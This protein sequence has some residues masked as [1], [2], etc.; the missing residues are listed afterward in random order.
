MNKS[1]RLAL[2]ATLAFG[3]AACGPSLAKKKD[4][5][6]IH[7][8]LGEVH[9]R[10]RN[11]ADALKELTK[12]IELNPGDANYYNALGLAYFMKGMNPEAYK[13]FDKAV[14]IDPKLSDAHL[15]KSALY[16]T[17]RKWDDAIKSAQEATRNIFYR[18]P[19]LAYNNIGWAYY[20]RGDYA[21][22]IDNYR[23]AIQANYNYA[24]AHYNMGLALE[25]SNRLKEAVESYKSAVTV[26]PA[27]LDA[28]FNL[29][30]ALAKSKDKAGAQKA[31]E[32]VVELAPES[33]K[34]QSAREYIKLIQ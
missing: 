14:S 12:A 20:N 33:D 17:E 22:A 13:S 5:A 24:L 21:N 16:I 31:F 8:R 32:K 34:G 27:Y 18:T 29:G 26:S 28:Y 9:L 7:Y 6:D 19:E 30:M 15:N 10:D 11:L 3:L 23:R 1:L 4:Q 25:K 2:A